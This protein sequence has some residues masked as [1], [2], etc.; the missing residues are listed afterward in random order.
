MYRNTNYYLYKF[1]TLKFVTFWKYITI[2]T[3]N[4]LRKLLPIYFIVIFYSYWTNNYHSKKKQL[5][6]T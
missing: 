1:E 2:C 3:R 5:I 4:P 6:T